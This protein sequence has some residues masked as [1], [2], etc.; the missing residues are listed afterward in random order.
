MGAVM[1]PKFFWLITAIFVPL[2]SPADAQQSKKVPRIGFLAATSASSNF[3]RVEAFR[4]GMHELGYIEGQNIIVEYRYAEDKP[5][6]VPN[7]VAELIRHKVEV[8]V[9]RADR[10]IK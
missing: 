5:E 2:L 4:Q 1:N 3:A 8:I 10:V 6:Q 7:L 9:A